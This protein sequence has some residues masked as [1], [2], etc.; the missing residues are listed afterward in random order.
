[1]NYYLDVQSPIRGGY[2]SSEQIDLLRIIQCNSITEL[3]DFIIHCD[4]ITNK[5][6]L[7]EVIKTMDLE[8]AK[9]IVFS[10]YQGTLVDHA[11]PDEEDFKNRM[12]HLEISS[13]EELMSI[14]NKTHPNIDEIARKNHHFTS[15]ERDQLKSEEMYDEMTAINNE[16]GNFNSILVGSGKIYNVI[17]RISGKHD[18][19]HAKRDLDFAKDN[20]KQVRYHSLL[21]K[22]DCHI[23]DGKSKEEI[24]AIL[25]EYV[26]RS[27]DFITEY[28]RTNK[29][30]ING[31][32]VPVINAVDL[33]NEIVSFDKNAEGK[34]YNI[35][36]EKYGLGMK[37]IMECFEYAFDHKP[38]GVSYLYNEPFLEDAERREKVIEVLKEIKNIRPDSIDT[39]GYQMH[40]TVGQDKE[41][42]RKC[43]SDFKKLQDQGMKIQITE[44]D[45]SLGKFDVPRVYGPN[46]D[47]TLGQVYEQK[48][49][50]IRELSEVINTSGVQLQG[51]SYWSLS[52][53]TDC[54]LERVRTKALQDGTI[55]DKK[56]IPTVCGGLIPTHQKLVKK[57]ELGQMMSDR[58]QTNNNQTKQNQNTSSPPKQKQNTSVPV[59]QA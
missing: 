36:E 47:A 51:V 18:F 43:F 54:N 6:K 24:K 33:F 58:K 35:W 55:S 38:E 30:V 8:E 13:Q 37:D 15:R 22:E 41:E 53:G 49:R 29:V 39:L 40:I 32:E 27:I 59:K 44:F 17:D 1:M 12:E 56:E 5:E 16:L 28:N 50:K 26:R 14:M 10:A 23:F 20:G 34:Y 31:K 4:Q 21:V 46:K 9:R 45:M 2:L 52:D 11:A 7:I 48:D 25:K 19:Y 57:Q 42:M 3:I